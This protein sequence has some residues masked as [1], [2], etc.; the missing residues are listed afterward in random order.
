MIQINN[1]DLQESLLTEGNGA[2]TVLAETIDADV[3]GNFV[4]EAV[5]QRLS[6]K[7]TKTVTLRGSFKKVGS[8]NVAVET[9]L[10]GGVIGTAG[11]LLALSGANASV[12]SNEGN[13]LFQVDGLTS[14]DIIWA[15]RV[16]GMKVHNVS[17]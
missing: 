17:E 8:N 13:I 7:A 4:Y 14:T 6:D 9:E 12:S 11:D 5:C 1:I 16:K 3:S 15:I 2:Q 10:L